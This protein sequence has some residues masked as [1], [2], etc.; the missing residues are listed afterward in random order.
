MRRRSLVVLSLLVAAVATI[1]IMT[2]GSYYES[3]SLLATQLPM[4]ALPIAVPLVIASLSRHHPRAIWSVTALILAV[5]WGYVLYTDLRP[6]QGIGPSFA[7]V[8]GWFAS[9]VASCVTLLWI[10]G[11][12][13]A[14]AVRRKRTGAG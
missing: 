5:G 11:A 14:S 7:I 4:L 13:I 6:D 9:V 3:V 10:T 8:M 2:V 12:A 1:A